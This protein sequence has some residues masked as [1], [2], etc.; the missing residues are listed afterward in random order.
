MEHTVAENIRT[1]QTN[2]TT[3]PITSTTP[4]IRRIS[5]SIPATFIS[6]TGENNRRDF[7]QINKS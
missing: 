1:S 2:A 6:G 5:F 7:I 3:S 4:I